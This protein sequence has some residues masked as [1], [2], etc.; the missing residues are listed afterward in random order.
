MTAAAFTGL[1]DTVFRASTRKHVEVAQGLVDGCSPHHKRVNLRLS[2]PS[3]LNSKNTKILGCSQRKKKSGVLSSCRTL[4][5]AWALPPWS[6]HMSITS[7]GLHYCLDVSRHVLQNNSAAGSFGGSG[8]IQIFA[9][10]QHLCD[11]CHL[12]N[13]KMIPKAYV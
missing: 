9:S 13:S 3:N 2:R 6:S 11:I 10:V 4:G 5:A 12:R 1:V 7:G 8:H